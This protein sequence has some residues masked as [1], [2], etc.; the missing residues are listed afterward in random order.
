[1]NLLRGRALLSL[2]LVIAS[3]LMAQPAAPSVAAKIRAH[4]DGQQDLPS[5]I[6]SFQCAEPPAVLGTPFQCHGHLAGGNLIVVQAKYAG[7]NRDIEIVS[8]VYYPVPIDDVR[9]FLGPFVVPAIAELRCDP[10][11]VPPQSFRCTGKLTDRSPIVVDAERQDGRLIIGP[12]TYHADP[13]SPVVRAVEA[14]LGEDVTSVRC[15]LFERATSELCLV[16]LAKGGEEGVKVLRKADDTFVA[17]DDPLWKWIRR[18]ALAGLVFGPILLI[19]SIWRLLTLFLR[20]VVARVPVI[21]PHEVSLTGPG[22]YVLSIEGPRF[23]NVRG[24]NYSLHERGTG[25]E[26]PLFPN[27]FRSTVSGVSRV[28][29]GV[30]RFAVERTGSYVVQTYVPP[31]RDASRLSVVISKA[32]LG[33]GF[34]AVVGIL[35]GAVATA[36]GL[37][38]L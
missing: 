31:D 12:I 23:S 1:M 11:P 2:T 25:Q 24:L 37:I 21:G 28:R 35:A 27:V 19:G 34:L 4:L 36:V 10:E 29:L 6:A 16:T 3:G 7:A 14:E 20:S 17:G 13:A 5:T 33:A 8:S 9:P 26:V 38:A 15:K 18:V 30:R 32:F 22:D